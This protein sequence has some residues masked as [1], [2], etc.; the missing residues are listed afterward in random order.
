MIPNEPEDH[1]ATNVSPTPCSSQDDTQIPTDKGEAHQPASSH[2]TVNTENPPEYIGN[3][4]ILK[5]MGQ[6]MA[7]VFKARQEEPARDV[8]LKIP[9]GG[10][11]MDPAV[12]DRFKREASL[13]ARMNH[14]SIVPV[15]DMGEIDGVPYYT[16]PFIEG[17]TLGSAAVN[18]FT[19]LDARIELF[20]ELCHVVGALHDGQLVHRDLKPANIMVDNFDKVRLLDF[21]LAKALDFNDTAFETQAAASMGTPNYMAP[22][23]TGISKEI[24]TAADVYSLG[25][26]LFEL[27][28][29]QL[30]YTFKQ[31]GPNEINIIRNFVPSPA[32]ETKPGLTAQYDHLVARCLEKTPKKRPQTASE[33]LRMLGEIDHSSSSLGSVVTPLEKNKRTVPALVATALILLCACIYGFIRHNNKPPESTAPTVTVTPPSTPPSVTPITATTPPVLLPKETAPSHGTEHPPEVVIPKVP[34]AALMV[35]ADHHSSPDASTTPSHAALRRALEHMG[36]QV[37]QAHG[38]TDGSIRETV[39]QFAQS[40]TPQGQAFFYYSGDTAEHQGQNLL[41]LKPDA[42]MPDGANTLPLQ[43][44]VDEIERQRADANIFVINSPH[45][46]VM[47][48]PF[49][50]REGKESPGTLVAMHAFPASANTAPP[51]ST[52]LSQHLHLPV[53]ISTLFEEA[54]LSMIASSPDIPP[55]LISSNLDADIYF[56]TPQCPSDTLASGSS[57]VRSILALARTLPQEFGIQVTVSPNRQVFLEGD[58]ITFQIRSNRDCYISLWVHQANGESHQLFPNAFDEKNRLEADAVHVIPHPATK[59]Y[60]IEVGP[61]FGIDAYQVIAATS[62]D[63]LAA[64]CRK[65]SEQYLPEEATQSLATTRGAA[66][67]SAFNRQTN[68]RVYWAT[69]EAMVISKPAR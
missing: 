14:P 2:F 57:N 32:S 40:I 36:F 55:P 12:R 48:S 37:Q 66:I 35:I 51:F 18:R 47:P 43:W 30:P 41:T 64:M 39:T 52:A 28:T 4:R 10:Q 65:F 58:Q 46:K 24:T 15:L 38:L 27:L 20:R 68:Q 6:S 7:I 16:M 22:E 17:D 42:S 54:R 60:V 44:V 8:V 67:K 34:K 1:D 59:D 25:V 26:I 56:D 9:R 45:A 11:L 49:T 63:E 62:A 69:G 3:Y 61:P 23:Q 13:A 33:V 31:F 5:I 53:T 19:N 29:D 50:A 21:G